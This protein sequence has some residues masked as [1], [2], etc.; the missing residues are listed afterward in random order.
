MLAAKSIS[1]VVP[2]AIRSANRSVAATRIAIGVIRSASPYKPLD[3][4]VNRAPPSRSAPRRQQF[5]YATL[6]RAYRTEA[7]FVEGQHSPSAQPRREKHG[8]AVSQPQVEIE[9]VALQPRHPGVLIGIQA[10]HNE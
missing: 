7:T 3:I 2:A 10:L 9:V 4:L 5:E 8:G 1:V 6:Q